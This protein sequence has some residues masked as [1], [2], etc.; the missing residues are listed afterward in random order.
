MFTVGSGGES[1]DDDSQSSAN[2]EE[3][4]IHIYAHDDEATTN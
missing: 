3:E 1:E 2:E 4:A